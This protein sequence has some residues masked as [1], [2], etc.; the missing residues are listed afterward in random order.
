V[1]ASYTTPAFGSLETP[2]LPRL[3]TCSAS[4]PSRRTLAVS[5]LPASQLDIPGSETFA[6]SAHNLGRHSAGKHTA[7]DLLHGHVGDG[8]IGAG[9]G[10]LRTGVDVVL[11]DSDA[12]I[13]DFREGDV[14]KVNVVDRAGGS[15]RH[16][17]DSDAV[18]RLGHLGV[19]EEDAVDNIVV[20]SSNRADRKTVAAGAGSA[21]EGDVLA[22]VDSN[23]VVLVLDDGTLDPNVVGITNVEPIRVVGPIQGIGILDV[24]VIA[25]G[26]SL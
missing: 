5:L 24:D 10:R 13:A 22:R 7:A 14:L 20:T 2:S 18:L 26:S 11:D 6:V 23:A 1:P 3:Q 16:S 12:E 17:L 9:V 4:H 15:G 8:D 25:A 21:G 19:K